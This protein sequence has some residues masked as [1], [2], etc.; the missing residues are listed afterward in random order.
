M[1]NTLKV[2]SS[3]GD[4]ITMALRNPEASGYI[5]YSISGLEPVDVDIKQT[6][7][8]S[9]LKYKYIKGFHK[10]REIR[11]SIIYDEYNQNGYSIDKL[12]GDLYKYF[13][14]NDLVA[15]YFTKDSG[16]IRLIRGYVYKNVG[17]YFSNMCGATISIL[18]PDSWFKLVQLSG[19]TYIE[20]TTTTSSAGT[21]SITYNG[22]KES[23]FV[24]K[25]TTTKISNLLGKRLTLTS[26]KG[27]STTAANATGELY[28]DVPSTYDRPNDLLTIDLSSDKMSITA[29]TASNT[30]ID[31]IGWLDASSISYRKDLPILVPSYNRVLL[32]AEPTYTCAFNVIYSTLYRGL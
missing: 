13:K 12:R 28:I 1:I 21:A 15:L 11:I 29:G 17:A 20:T 10:Y 7:L 5:I 25:T 2:V 19:S 6:Q 9:G 31:C 3:N 4:N 27:T 32:K 14:T 26:Y 23:R 24:L 30:P 18:C 16:D 22:D 8:V